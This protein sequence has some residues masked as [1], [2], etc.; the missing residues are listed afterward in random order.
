M[1]TFV[2]EVSPNL[3]LKLQFAYRLCWL[4]L[5][6]MFGI[7]GTYLYSIGI[8]QTGDVTGGLL[9]LFNIQVT[10]A[11]PGLVVMVVSLIV[12]LIGAM[13]ARVIIRKGEII[14]TAPAPSPSPAPPPIPDRAVLSGRECRLFKQLSDFL[15]G[16]SPAFAILNSHGVVDIESMCW[17]A[18]P[19]DVRQSA[20][21]S[22]PQYQSQHRDSPISWMIESWTIKCR[23]I[24][25]TDGKELT[26]L[27]IEIYNDDPEYIRRFAYEDQRPRFNAFAT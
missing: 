17:Q 10:N 25:L 6:G 18:V 4:A 16:R 1:P 14:V 21:S 13:S 8:T 2:E 27:V 19:D 9:K 22:A 3:A 7:F 24:F 12:S 26:W 20:V 23:P 15:S 11:G 5:A